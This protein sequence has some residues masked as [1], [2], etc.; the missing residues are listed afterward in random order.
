M[1]LESLV[2]WAWFQWPLGPTNVG[3]SPVD[4][5]AKIVSLEAYYHIKSA[6]VDPKLM[7]TS[8]YLA[9][10]SE[11]FLACPRLSPSHRKIFCT[12]S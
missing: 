2:L 5:G 7:Q 1:L 8:C 4:Q 3:G 9:E 10:D 11:D 12:A 6:F